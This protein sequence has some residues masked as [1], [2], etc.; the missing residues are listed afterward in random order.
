[1]H[2]LWGSTSGGVP[3]KQD[4]CTVPAPA[5]NMPL[6]QTTGMICQCE[7]LTKTPPSNASDVVMPFRLT[8]TCAAKVQQQASQQNRS[9]PTIGSKPKSLGQT[10]I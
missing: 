4:C 10:C 7:K 6:L 5:D 9:P 2:V 1:M 8:A 3:Q